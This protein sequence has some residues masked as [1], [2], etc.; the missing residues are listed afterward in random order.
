M[1]NSA[2]TAHHIARTKVGTYCTPGYCLRYTRGWYAIPSKYGRA[3]TAW[4]YAIGKHYSATG[5]PV[6]APVFWT[7]GSAGHIAIMSTGGYIVSTDAPT[8]GR[9]GLVP[10]SWPAQRW[11]LRF[12]GWAEG[13]NGVRIPGLP[14]AVSP[15][16][17]A[18]PPAGGAV[19]NCANLHYGATNADVIDLQRALNAHKLVGGSTLPVTGYY[20][21]KTDH[22]VRLCQQQHGYGSDGW[23]KSFVGP[24]QARHLGLVPQ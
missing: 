15:P 10:L 2:L 4:S 16:P 3:D 9:I 5:I 11:G 7:G 17:V 6:G 24:S 19:V 21:D 23:H 14:P 20:G 13:F 8:R 1:A 18:P 12:A 22:E